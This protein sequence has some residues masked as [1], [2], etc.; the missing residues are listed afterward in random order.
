MMRGATLP[1]WDECVMHAMA[2]SMPCPPDDEP[3]GYA[4]EGGSSRL[5]SAQSA[6]AGFVRISTVVYHRASNGWTVRSVIDGG[7]KG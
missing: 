3:S 2:Y 6:S 5:A 7:L 1:A 4:Y